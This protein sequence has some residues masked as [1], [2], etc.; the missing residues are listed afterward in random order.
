[1]GRRRAGAGPPVL[2]VVSTWVLC[3]S[4]C[5]GLCLGAKAMAE[6]QEGGGRSVKSLDTVN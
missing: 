4:S 5:G 3:M 1:M 6:P 2:A